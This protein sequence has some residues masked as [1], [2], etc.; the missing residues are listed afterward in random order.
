M[1]KLFKVSLCVFC[2]TLFTIISNGCGSSSSSFGSANSPTNTASYDYDDF[3][4]AIPNDTTPVSDLA[5]SPKVISPL[6]MLVILLEYDN[7]VIQ[8]SPTKWAKKIFGFGEKQLNGYYKEIS[9]GR[10]FFS[11]VQESYG[12]AND[13]IVKVHLAKNHID[14]DINSVFFQPRLFQDIKKAL[15]IANKYVDFSLY[16]ING[17][18][19]IESG[20]AAIVFVVAGYEDSFVGYHIHNGIWAHQSSLSPD[21]APILDGVTVANE[22]YYGKYAIFGERHTDRF[23]SYD[24][25]IGILA[26]ELGH[27]VFDLPDLYN[28]SGERGG[29]G[30]FGLMGGGSWT[31]KDR[32]E[33]YGDTPVHMCAWSKSFIGWFT[34]KIYKNTSLTL[35]Q[36]ASP[37]YN[38]AKIPISANHYYLLENRNDSGFDRGLRD[39]DG[40]FKGGMLIWHINQ[41]KLTVKYFASNTVNI[42]VSDKGVDVV[43]AKDPVL[44]AVAN[45]SGNANALFF[46]PNRTSFGYKVTDISAPGSVMNININ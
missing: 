5:K 22:K 34:P 3:I 43:E 8:S 13:G 21:E 7:Q 44:D 30:I 46:D 45:A 37:S 1:R 17:D 35:V 41:K 9:A 36:T 26:H 25:T 15:Q 42:D 27:A 29:I 16:D 18:G 14:T 12:V 11:P 2:L 32:F 24:A 33:H 20:E 23:D 6:P 38:I 10:F 4:D 31:R 40:E 19:A 39:L 28:V